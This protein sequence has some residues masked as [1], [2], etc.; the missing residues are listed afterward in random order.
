MVASVTD[1]IESTKDTLETTSVG[2]WSISE[3]MQKGTAARTNS[4]NGQVSSG[5]G[6][7]QS[8]CSQ[9]GGAK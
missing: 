3:S 9:Q 8:V 2:N 1:G 4:Q 6:W 5:M 7:S